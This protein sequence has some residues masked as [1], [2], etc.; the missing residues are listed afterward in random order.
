MYLCGLDVALTAI[1]V[2]LC[3]YSSNLGKIMEHHEE[4]IRSA[5]VLDFLTIANEYCLIVEECGKYPRDTLLGYMHRILPLL[6]LKGSLLPEIRPP[7]D[8][9][10]E[11]FVTEEQWENCLKDLI[12]QMDNED[13]F[14]FVPHQHHHNSDSGRDKPEPEKGRI[15]EHLADIYQ[16]MKDFVLLFQKPLSSSKEHAVASCTYL[17]YDN[18]GHKAL[19]TAT[20]IHALLFPCCQH[21]HE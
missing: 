8:D 16:D 11:R 2:F 6:Y 17:F 10:Y 18:W 14:W 21:D 15:S 20:M 4:G 3:G 9:L 5:K 12:K 1:Y 13:V 19:T 7:D